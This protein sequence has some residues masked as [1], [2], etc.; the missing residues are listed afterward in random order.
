MES[1]LRANE[2]REER[3]K[4]LA[5]RLQEYATRLDEYLSSGQADSEILNTYEQSLRLTAAQLAQ[6]SREKA[7]ETFQTVALGA[8]NKSKIEALLEY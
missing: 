4:E 6:L 8:K 2:K 1:I 3:A 5:S 7:N